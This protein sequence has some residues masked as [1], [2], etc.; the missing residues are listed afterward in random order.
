LPVLAVAAVVI[1]ALAAVA[2]AL[3][4]RRRRRDASPRDA[5]VLELERALRRTGRPAAYGTTLRG[6]E[7]RLASLPGAAAY[8]RALRVHR[9]AAAA[10][11]P[12]PAERRALRRALGRGLGLRGRARALWALPP[13]LH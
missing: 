6:L 5:Q 1:A 13:R 4:G 7:R 3:P 10:P 11:P 9:F 2:L 8:L 12:T